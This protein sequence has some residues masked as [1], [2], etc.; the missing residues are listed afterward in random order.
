MQGISEFGSV[1]QGFFLMI[2]SVS[3][4]IDLLEYFANLYDRTHA[5]SKL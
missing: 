2:L 5:P 4:I 1:I 3:L